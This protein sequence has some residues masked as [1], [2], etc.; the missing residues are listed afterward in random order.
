M[1]KAKGIPNYFWAEAVIC[2]LYLINKLATRSVPNTTLIE[3][4]SGFKPNVQHLKVF[5]SIT[6]AHVPKAARSKLDDK[7]MKTIFIGYKHGRYKLYNPMKKKV[8]VSHDVTFAED[9]E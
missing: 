3:A 2:A 8:I 7:V 1:L 4:W 9:E 5:G 6:Y